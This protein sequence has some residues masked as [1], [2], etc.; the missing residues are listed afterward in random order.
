[1]GDRREPTDH[2]ELDPAADQPIEEGL[3]IRQRGAP[4]PLSKPARP[5]GLGHAPGGVPRASCGDC[6]PA[7]TCRSH[8]PRRLPTRTVGRK[9]RGGSCSPSTG[10]YRE[11]PASP[12]LRSRSPCPVRRGPTWQRTVGQGEKEELRIACSSPGVRGKRPR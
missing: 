12:S 10:W 3:K 1:M 7:R 8:S 5:R 2:H 4:W 11:A 9:R 6:S